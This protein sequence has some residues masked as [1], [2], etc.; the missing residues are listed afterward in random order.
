MLDLIGKRVEPRGY[1][2]VKYPGSQAAQFYNLI[3]NQGQPLDVASH[4]GRL[5]ADS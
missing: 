2:E 4:E 1:F 5:L 3:L